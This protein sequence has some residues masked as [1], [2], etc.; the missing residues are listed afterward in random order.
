MEKLNRKLNDFLE[1][2]LNFKYLYKMS[3]NLKLSVDFKEIST[4]SP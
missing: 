2:I 3:E 4:F 1:K